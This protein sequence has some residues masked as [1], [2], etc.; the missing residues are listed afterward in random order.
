MFALIY[1]FYEFTND[2]E[3]TMVGL[4]IW[5]VMLR[6]ILFKQHDHIFSYL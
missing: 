5:L 2:L 3:K 6:S 4:V 1:A